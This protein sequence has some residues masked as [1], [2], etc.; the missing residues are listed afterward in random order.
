MANR[1]E[2]LS[3]I[4]SQLAQLAIMERDSAVQRAHDRLA[5]RLQPIVS[6]RGLPDGTQY[7]IDV[8]PTGVAILTVNDGNP[9]E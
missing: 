7:D 2:T 1:T 4:E 6:A 5:A 3:P 9:A 8:G